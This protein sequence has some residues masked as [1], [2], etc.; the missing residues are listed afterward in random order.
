VRRLPNWLPYNLKSAPEYNRIL[1]AS[2][3]DLPPFPGQQGKPLY[4]YWFKP[5]DFTEVYLFEGRR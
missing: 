4:L 2:Q 5:G 3:A 1:I